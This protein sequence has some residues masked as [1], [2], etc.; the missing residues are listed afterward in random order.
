MATYA[1]LRPAQRGWLA[2]IHDLDQPQPIA[3]IE[4]HV[5]PP[6]AEAARW[7]TLAGWTVG[8]WQPHPAGRKLWA[9][10][11]ERA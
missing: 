8:D 3:H 2:E 6:Y 7:F 4:I 1:T 9:A 11:V 10:P 5:T